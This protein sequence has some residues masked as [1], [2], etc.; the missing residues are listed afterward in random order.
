VASS[1]AF[2]GRKRKK[3]FEWSGSLRH[4]CRWHWV[5]HSVWTLSFR[6]AHSDLHDLEISQ[7]RMR[8]AESWYPTSIWSGTRR[9]SGHGAW[10]FLVWL[11]VWGYVNLESSQIPVRQDL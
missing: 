10:N 11:A 6:D 7:C 4:L 8:L 1:L 2:A 5:H 3:V 9:Q